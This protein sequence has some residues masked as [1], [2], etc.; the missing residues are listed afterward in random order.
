MVCRESRLRYTGWKR[1][2][3]HQVAMVCRESRLRY[4]E[5]KQLIQM[6][7]LWFAGNRG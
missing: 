6:Y 4:T 7:A 2:S 1:R 3:I 5:M